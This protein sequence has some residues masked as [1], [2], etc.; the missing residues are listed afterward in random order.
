MSFRFSL[1]CHCDLL[2][3]TKERTSDCVYPNS[4]HLRSNQ[5]VAIQQLSIRRG[6]WRRVA[7]LL[8]RPA[9]QRGLKLPDWRVARPRI[10]SRGRLARVL[11]RLPSTS[12]QPSPP[13]THC[14][15]VGDG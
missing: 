11:H 12:S 6:P 10:A 15:I 14:P 1:P 9:F 4:L 3:P 7:A 8:A 5:K 13:L 2:A